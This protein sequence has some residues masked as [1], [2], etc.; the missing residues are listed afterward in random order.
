M[1]KRQPKLNKVLFWDI[2]PRQI[3]YQKH[4]LFVI[5]RVLKYG[6]INDW[7]EVKRYYGREDLVNNVLRIRNFDKKTCNFLSI[8]FDLPKKK[9]LCTKKSLRQKQSFVWNY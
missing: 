1:N 8:I 2:E 5:E 7:R 3:D 9:F 4:R 6:D